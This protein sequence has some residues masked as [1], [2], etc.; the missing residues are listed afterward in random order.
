M[1]FRTRCWLYTSPHIPSEPPPPRHNRAIRIRRPT[2]HL[3]LRRTTH[4]NPRHAAMRALIPT[5]I[6][7]H[8]PLPPPLVPAREPPLAARG[9][10][11]LRTNDIFAVRP[12]AATLRTPLEQLRC[13]RFRGGLK[14]RDLLAGARPITTVSV[15]ARV[16]RP[17]PTPYATGRG[18]D[19]WMTH[20]DKASRHL[21]LQFL[22]VHDRPP[23]NL[24]LRVLSGHFAREP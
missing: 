9:C 10:R 1:M 21:G 7:L 14:T 11:T 12:A 13:R 22:R 20:G 4:T 15:A 8:P 17:R 19:C 16:A 2:R 3:R 23:R 6:R 18:N 24:N 5:P